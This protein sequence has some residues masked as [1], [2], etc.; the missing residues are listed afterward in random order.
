MCNIWGYL[1]SALDSNVTNEKTDKKWHRKGLFSI[2]IILT[3][4]VLVSV[5]HPN[6]FFIYAQWPLDPLS[7][8]NVSNEYTDWDKTYKL[9]KILGATQLIYRYNFLPPVAGKDLF[10]T[11][12][13]AVRM[14]SNNVFEMANMCGLKFP[15]FEQF[16]ME[17]LYGRSPFC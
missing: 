7:T 15:Q 10:E 11:Q 13:A 9:Y 12:F 4:V 5:K 2:L 1:I 16:S 3:H 17:N 14:R 6:F 8:E